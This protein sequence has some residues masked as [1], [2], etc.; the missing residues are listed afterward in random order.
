M[1]KSLKFSL[2]LNSSFLLIEYSYWGP[3]SKRFNILLS[4]LQS[5]DNRSYNSVFSGN[6]IFTIGTYNGLNYNQ[7]IKEL[8]DLIITLKTS[9]EEI[10]SNSNFI[11]SQ[12]RIEISELNNR[13]EKLM[14]S[15]NQYEKNINSNNNS[16][17]NIYKLLNKLA[18]IVWSLFQPMF[19]FFK[20]FK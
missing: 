20:Y 13:N 2:I 17:R 19:N 7:H 1:I 15:I 18:G 9:L 11:T 16:I 12:L 5:V 10:K 14:V 6:S 8:N 4:K 3:F